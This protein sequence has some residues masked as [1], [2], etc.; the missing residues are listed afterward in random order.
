MFLLYLLNSE[1]KLK[2][3]E[4][5][6]SYVHESLVSFLQDI[7]AFQQNGELMRL[8]LLPSLYRKTNKNGHFP[9][10]HRLLMNFK[11]CMLF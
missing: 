7:C 8:V 2:D 4:Q 6:I 11:F 5:C 10:C 1:K 9:Y 3:I